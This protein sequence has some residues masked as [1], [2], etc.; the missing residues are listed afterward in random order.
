MHD[1]NQRA[2]PDVVDQPG[3]ADEHDGGHV[4]DDLLFEILQAETHIHDE[5]RGKWISSIAAEETTTIIRWCF[6]PAESLFIWY[7]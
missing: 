3:E 4:V 7:I 5:K 1:H 2:R 6:V